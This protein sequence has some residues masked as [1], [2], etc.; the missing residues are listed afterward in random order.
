MASVPA[1]AAGRSPGHRGLADRDPATLGAHVLAAWD[2]FLALVGEVDL[3]APARLRGWTGRDVLVHLGAWPEHAATAD[4]IASARAGGARLATV[5]GNDPAFLAAHRCASRDEV[6]AA[7]RAERASVEAYFRDDAG[8]LGHRLA[9]SM[10]GPLPAST[11]VDAA[12]YEL[13]VHALDL[14]PCGAPHPSATLTYAGLGALADTTAAL[15][16][17]LGVSA[18]IALRAPD[19]GWVVTIDPDG[20]RTAE[21]DGAPAP[22]V[23]S[24]A[25][26]MLLD[27]SA[28]RTNPVAAVAS[29]AI[30][31][32]GVPTLLRLSPIVEGVPG[33]PGR[34]ALRLATTGL[35]RAGRLLGRLAGR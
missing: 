24:G 1:D 22:G 27:A 10:L 7:L 17:R 35:A 19:G 5:A 20:W 31:L 15:G 2:A 30:R 8:E 9:S 14:G 26:A 21:D 16:H 29:G 3:D 23:V 33:L 13:A 11:I 32:H 18:T 34:S 4:V 28:G 25:A 6:T 12:C